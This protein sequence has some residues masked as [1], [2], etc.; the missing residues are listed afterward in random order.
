MYVLFE[1]DNHGEVFVI[2]FPSLNKQLL[3]TLHLIH[4]GLAF[5]SVFNKSLLSIQFNRGSHFSSQFMKYITPF[6][7]A[8]T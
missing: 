1:R 6:V 4:E 2:F 5:V 3:I 7:Q 8:R